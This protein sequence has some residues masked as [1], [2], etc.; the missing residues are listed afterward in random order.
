MP[1]RK[2]RL[3]MLVE[4]ARSCSSSRCIHG[5]HS[6][7]CGL[8]RGIASTRSLLSQ[9]PPNFAGSRMSH[10]ENAVTLD[11]GDRASDGK[12]LAGGPCS[13]PLMVRE[14]CG[15]S[16][17]R[18]GGDVVARR[19]CVGSIISRCMLSS[20]AR[21]IIDSTPT[22]DDSTRSE[23]SSVKLRADDLSDDVGR[24]GPSM[25][26][27]CLCLV[28]GD[29]FASPTCKHD[30][31]W[32]LVWRSNIS[33]SLVAIKL[34]P[35]RRVVCPSSVSR[36]WC[37]F[38][39]MLAAGVCG[40]VLGPCTLTQQLIQRLATSP[41]LLTGIAACTSAMPKSVADWSSTCLPSVHR[42]QLPCDV[43]SCSVAKPLWIRIGRFSLSSATWTMPCV[44]ACY[45]VADHLWWSVKRR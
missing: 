25:T 5:L 12:L 36:S 7:C 6:S 44:V 26:T 4:P 33:S 31:E 14:S 13:G 19:P 17:G 39:S 37:S 10:T 1:R 11:A 18:P 34:V 24:C 28:P 9:P 23:L 15:G 43:I 27:G 45:F 16:T 32:W 8:R 40:A 2:C 38:F 20:S 22:A 30:I 29:S 3:L 21:L 42:H 35:C 41:L